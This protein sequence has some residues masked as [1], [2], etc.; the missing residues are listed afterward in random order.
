MSKIPD[1]K[2]YSSM[3]ECHS[4]VGQTLI[5]VTSIAHREF[6]NRLD[7]SHKHENHMGHIIKITAFNEVDKEFK[8]LI[9]GCL[10]R[11]ALK[12]QSDKRACKGGQD[13]NDDYRGYRPSN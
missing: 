9:D 4:S 13:C 1:A 10:L 2:L 3:F 11:N 8:M 6:Q 5:F 12:L 7:V